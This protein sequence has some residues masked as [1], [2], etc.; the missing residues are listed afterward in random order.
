VPGS[1]ACNA[2]AW[3]KRSVPGYGLARQNDGQHKQMTDTKIKSSPR[4]QFTRKYFIY[5]NIF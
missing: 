3:S 1:A 4:Y 5:Q 2:K